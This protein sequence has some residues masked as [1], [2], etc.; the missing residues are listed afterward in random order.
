MKGE[1][2]YM[3]NEALNAALYEKMAAEQKDFKDW[4]VKQSPETI[5]AHANQ[6]AVREDILMTMEDLALPDDSAK[7]LWTSPDAMAEIYDDFSKLD[8]VEHMDTV[9][10]CIEQRANRLQERQSVQEPPVYCQSFDYAQERHE[11]TLYWASYKENMACKQA[12]EAAIRDGFDGMSLSKQGAKEVV[13]EFGAQRVSFVLACTIQQKPW[14]GRFSQSNKAWAATI[15]QAAPETSRDCMVESHPGVLNVFISQARKEM[16]AAAR[17]QP[18][19]QPKEKKPS[20]RAQL[21]ANATQTQKER[22]AGQVHAKD[23][24][25][26]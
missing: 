6:Y 19:E 2:E 23:G 15:P 11:D 20:I 24:E 26:R 22:P 4:L 10:E 1:M 9:R 7:A 3:D 18:R 5:L 14:E 12:I 13:K 17:E 8:A 21:T 16:D 25:V